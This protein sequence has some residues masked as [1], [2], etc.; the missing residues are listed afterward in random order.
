MLAIQTPILRP[1]I[2]TNS[3]LQ[4]SWA[5]HQ[6]EVREAQRL[7]HRVFAQEL[8]AQLRPPP[9]TPVGHDVDLFDAHCEHLLVRAENPDGS[10]GAV[11]ACYRLL[12]PTAARRVGGLYAETEFD[13]TRLRHERHRIAELGRACVDPAHRRGSALLMMWGA[14]AEY[15]QRERLDL[16]I[17]C[18]S[19]DARDGG[20]R[21][22]TLWNQLVPEHLAAI[23]WQVRPRNP[24][25]PA[26]MQA[27]GV[28]APALLRGYLKANAKLIGAPAW[29]GNF[30][31]A[32]FPLL[33][34]LG[35]M[36][37]SYRRRF[38]VSPEQRIASA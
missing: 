10:P 4:L 36:P 12:S 32:D 29:D 7:R 1:A 25:H 13:L 35:D 30:R 5:R 2:R 3:P 37:G 16:A 31:C 27:G 8:G 23:E 6:D 24:L 28:E 22:W 11:V 21:A 34:R 20:S 9:G 17:G 18:A 26:P 19:V 15:L 38:L 33:L 14:I